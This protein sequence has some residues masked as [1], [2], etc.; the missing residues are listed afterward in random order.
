MTVGDPDAP[1]HPQFFGTI[2]FDS[3]RLTK[4]PSDGLWRGD[5]RS[6]E[7]REPGLRFSLGAV[8]PSFSS[9]R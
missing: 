9:L 2:A 6:G 8:C 4:D 3:Q 1:W 7:S 5:G